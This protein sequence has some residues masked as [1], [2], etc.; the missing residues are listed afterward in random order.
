MSRLDPGLSRWRG[1]VLRCYNVA[2]LRL[3]KLELDV[4]P[5]LVTLTLSLLT[6]FSGE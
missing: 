3:L 5:Q 6:S 4:R 2:Q 1:F